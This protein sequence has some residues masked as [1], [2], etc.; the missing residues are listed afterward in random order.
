MEIPDF[1]NIDTDMGLKY[2]AGNKKLYVKIL[3]DF[4]DKQKDLKLESLDDESLERV[5]HTIKGL[6]I[7]MGAVALSKISEELE[8]TLNRALFSQ[9]YNEL[10][11]VLD[12]LKD[13]GTEKISTA[14]LILGAEKR[15]E[16]FNALLHAAKT[17][18]TK[19]CYPVMEEIDTYQLSKE[20]EVLFNKIKRLMKKY[21]FK[22]MVIMLEKEW[23]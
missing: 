13:M 16:L 9:F 18:L 2:L 8:L 23:K 12:E 1:V 5:V 6:S 17:K 14:K 4:Y 19:K 22:D 15:E 21:K 3:N 10:S 7:N 11:K 20:D